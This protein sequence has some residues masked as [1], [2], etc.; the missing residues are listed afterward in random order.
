MFTGFNTLRIL[1]RRISPCIHAFN[2]L[3]GHL[4]VSLYPHVI[5]H[6]TTH[7]LASIELMFEAKGAAH[8]LIYFAS[9]PIFLHHSIKF[10]LPDNSNA[11]A[12]FTLTLDRTLSVLRFSGE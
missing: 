2:P 12:P 7:Q 8:E 5:M 4:A 6:N 11:N 9:G 3:S 10:P 1:T